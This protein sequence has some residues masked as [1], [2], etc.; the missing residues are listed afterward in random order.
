MVYGWKG[1]DQGRGKELTTKVFE[2]NFMK[3][4]CFRNFLTYTIHMYILYMNINGNTI[5][6][7]DTIGNQTKSLLAVVRCFLLSYW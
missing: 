7:P 4:H 3:I 1:I 2:I 5:S 6:L